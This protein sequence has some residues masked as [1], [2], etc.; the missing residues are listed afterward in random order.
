MSTAACA[1]RVVVAVPRSGAHRLQVRNVKPP[2]PSRGTPCLAMPHMG[3]GLS[4]LARE[5]R[6]RE[7]VTD[8]AASATG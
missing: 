3:A 5:G 6:A 4:R 7:T 8:G 1:E 2:Y